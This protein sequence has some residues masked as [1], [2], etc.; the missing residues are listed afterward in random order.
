MLDSL[1]IEF[2]GGS[3]IQAVKLQHAP[4]ADPSEHRTSSVIKSTVTL[5]EAITSE[6]AEPDASGVASP[7]VGTADLTLL[8]GHTM[9]FELEI[10]LREPGESI[11][12][13]VTL[14]LR[15]ESF[16]LDHVSTFTEPRNSPLWFLSPSAKTRV[17]HSCPL[18][19]R[20]LPRPPKMDIRELVLLSQYY[21]NE[22]I[23]LAFEIRNAEAVDALVQIDAVLLGDEDPP[24]L[25]LTVAGRDEAHVSSALDN[26]E[27][28]LLGV[29][30]GS[31]ASGKAVSIGIRLQPVDRT[32]RYDLTL[33]AV[34]HLATD[35]QTPITQ[36]AV[37][38]INVA[39]PFEANYDLL[40]RLNSDP[41][42]SLFDASG[43]QDL[44]GHR[45]ASVVPQ[46]ISQTWCLLT[47][48]ASLA[49]EELH[50]VDLDISV[51]QDAG[52]AA[53]YRVVK[54]HG[55]PEAG[56]R[57]GPKTIEEA[58]FD[59]IA[60]KHLLD[61]RSPSP[62]DASL[63]IKWTR[64][65]RCAQDAAAGEHVTT[66]DPPKPPINTTVVTV[67]RFHLFG[68]EP[69]VLASVSYLPGGKSEA[70]EDTGQ[71][72]RLRRHSPAVV[73]DVVLENASNHFLTFGVSL[74]P[75][76]EFAFSGPKQ[77]T[78]HVLPVSRRAVAY[79][80]LPLVRGAWIRPALVV[81]DK[82][83]QKVL[84]VIPTT[85]EGMRLDKDGFSVWVPPLEDEEDE[86][87]DEAKA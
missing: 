26:E 74:E 5:R 44:S 48:Y 67:P 68:I 73:L 56:R 58:A 70:G 61:D 41:W 21:A 38:S 11:A 50:I 83:F 87:Q 75:S 18:A 22:P 15:S 78:L 23:D 30:L 62:L 19:L 27:R 46:G 69:R 12:A 6:P 52:S 76:A 13:A 64:P 1:R 55:L 36:T 33:R 65:A 10:H 60:Q 24:P 49:A 25:A 45:D 43:L 2:Q 37:F 9:V 42:P 3:S 31:L 51:Q 29:G 14:S 80:L 72:P 71:A 77:T 8:P 34:Y 20:I 28:R 7:L 47:R 84:A 86:R 53:Q 81:R 54:K 57:L 63:L 4:D 35:L 79:R 17:A 40:P 59:I 66:T 16:D 39:T 85:E 82:H 32:S